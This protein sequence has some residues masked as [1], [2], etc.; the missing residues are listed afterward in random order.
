MSVAIIAMNCRFPGG[1][2]DVSKIRDLIVEGKTAGSK[3]PKDKFNA[4]VYYYPSHTRH[5]A[6]CGC[7]KITA[8]YQKGITLQMLLTLI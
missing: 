3:I 1:A 7:H 4:V 5:D 2:D 6:I 8:V